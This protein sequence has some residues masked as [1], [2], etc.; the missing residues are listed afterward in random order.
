MVDGVEHEAR[1][2][3]ADRP[4]AAGADQQRVVEERIAREHQ[5][6]LIERV[7]VLHLD[8]LVAV[9]HEHPRVVGDLEAEDDVA[10]GGRLRELPLVADLAGEQIDAGRHRPV[11]Q[12]RLG[13]RELIVLGAVALLRGDGERFAAAEEV[14]GLE[15]Q[16]AEEAVELRHAGAERQLVAV[17]LLE[18]QL[19]VDLVVGVRASS[20]RR[21]LRPRAA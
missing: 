5:R 18:L 1:P 15:R 2:D 6:I 12:E 8:L 13:E 16:L 10:A 3:L 19:D 4:L 9:V 20:G 14:R 7:E 11:E 17:L 21:P